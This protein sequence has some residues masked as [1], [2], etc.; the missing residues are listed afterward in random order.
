MCVRVCICCLGS[1]N[2]PLCAFACVI[3]VPADGGLNGP[4]PYP[5]P[6]P[7]P[8]SPTH[9]VRRRHPQLNNWHRLGATRRHS[10]NNNDTGIGNRPA[11]AAG[12]AGEEG[13][14]GQ[15]FALGYTY[16]CICIWVYMLMPQLVGLITHREPEQTTTTG[17]KDCQL[18]P[19]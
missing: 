7:L 16:I 2:A 15:R 1:C 12:V 19:G 18:I 4:Y 3:S 9:A 10:N 11:R 5:Y 13:G 14:M 17:I 6:H 8:V